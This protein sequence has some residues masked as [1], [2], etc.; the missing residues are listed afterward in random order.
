[1][2]VKNAT[3]TKKSLII[4]CQVLQTPSWYRGMGKYSKAFIGAICEQGEITDGRGL[5][6]LFNR[7]LEK[8]SEAIDF[9]Q[10]QYPNAEIIY[11]DLMNPKEPRTEHSIAPVIAANKRT[12]DTLLEDRFPHQKPDFL[13]LALYLDE[14]CPVFPSTHVAEKLLIYYDSIPYLYHERYGQFAGFFE[15]FY[16][17]HTATVYEA[18]KLLTISKTVANDLHVMFGLPQDVIYNIDGASIPRLTH[19]ATKPEALDIKRDKFILMPTGQELRKNNTRAVRA[20]EQFRSKRGS[21]VKL[22]ITSYFTEE[23]QADLQTLSDHILFSG[24]VSEG[25][26]LWLF[27]N[28]QFVLFPSE[29]EGLGLPIL[30]A[31]EQGKPI[32]CSDISVFRE[33]SKTAFHFFDPL[34]IDA[35][36]ETLEAVTEKSK[37][38]I[39]HDKQYAEILHKY[40]WVNTA[41][42]FAEA[43]ERPAFAENISKK[44]IAIFCPDPTGFSAIGKIVTESHA[45]Y[46]R[47]FDI[48]YY[49]D[50]G[51]NHQSIRPNLLSYLAPSYS[52]EEFTA[53]DYENYDAVI[54]HIGNSEYHLETIHVALAFP[55]Y[56]ILH[57]TYLTGAYANLVELGYMTPERADLEKQLDKLMPDEG[58]DQTPNSANLTSIV[59]NQRA[60]ITHS[61]YAAKAAKHKLI[62]K[63]IPIKKINLPVDTPIFSDIVHSTGGSMNIAFAGIIAKV[64]GT[65]IIEMIA[66]SEEFAGY[67]INIFGYSAVEPERLEKLRS[68]PHV[69]LVTNPNDH[70]FQTMMASTDVL[71]N[72]RLAYKGETSLTTLEAMRFGATVMVRD[73]GWYSEL[74]D[75]AVVKVDNPEEVIPTLLKVLS[76][77]QLIQDRKA[78]DMDY[79]RKKHSHKSY[80][81]GMH[82][83]IEDN[84]TQ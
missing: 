52:S 14:A 20:F 25:E 37:N 18:T 59:N 53:E 24:N 47:Y 1:M 51:P 11:A 34:N 8:N 41:K 56:V 77:E 66:A 5:L 39:N 73:F 74:P 19:T 23:A 31:V 67:N 28:C 21:D 42:K 65:D 12:L 17:P 57:D 62:K 54:Y 30:E 15:H 61:E 6:F 9:I 69:K 64:K 44:K 83:L 75:E 60:I 35:I 3:Q 22:V 82:G 68:L 81:E 80:A 76:D 29:Y 32:A 7:N 13:I 71:I 40:T 72:V 79:I 84:K 33:M 50:K 45:W 46:A 49:F 36:A 2:A 55:G 58:S 27:Q 26:I 63:G 43:L 70:E 48:V 38:P 4:D 16:L 78:T 10:E